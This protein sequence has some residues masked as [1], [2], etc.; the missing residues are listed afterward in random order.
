MNTRIGRVARHRSRLGRFAP[1]PK[2]ESFV[3][4][5]ASGDDDDDDASGSTHEDEMTTSQ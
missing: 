2:C 1:S 4:S 5:Y 3:T